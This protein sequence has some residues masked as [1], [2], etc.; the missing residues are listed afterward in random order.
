MVE[1]Q[2]GAEAVI[3]DVMPGISLYSWRNI[4]ISMSKKHTGS[5]EYEIYLH[6]GILWGKL[7]N[8]LRHRTVESARE[9][10]TCL[11][12]DIASTVDCR[13]EWNDTLKVLNE[14]NC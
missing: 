11:P 1:I 9:K 7:Q 14:G 3:K 2:D 8:N 6:R 13:G 4:S 12:T 10:R 5:K